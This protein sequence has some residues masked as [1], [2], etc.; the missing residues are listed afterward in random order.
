MDKIDQFSQWAPHKKT[1]GIV[2]VRDAKTAHMPYFEFSPLTIFHC[3][4][5]P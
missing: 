5:S 1:I 4:I 3:P 2:D